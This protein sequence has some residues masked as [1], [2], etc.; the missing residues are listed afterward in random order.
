M[1]NFL[2]AK[3][4]FVLQELHRSTDDRRIADRIKAVL[5]LD[6]GWSS[7]D[8]CEAL[9]IDDSTIR[10]YRKLYENE[11][12]D[13]LIDFKYMGGQCH[14]TEK[15]LQKLE[16]HLQKEVYSSALEIVEHV[17]EEFDVEYTPEGMVKLL[18]RRGFVYKKTKQLPGKADAQ[19]QKE[20]IAKYRKVKKNKGKHDKIYFVDGTHPLHNSQPGYGWIKKGEIKEV[21]SNAGR[22]RVN[23]NGALDI[24]DLDFRFT[25]DKSINAQSTIKLFRKLE[26]A[27]PLAKSIYVITDN[28]KYYRAKLVKDYVEN[29]RIK[30]MFLPAYSPNL[31]IIERLWKFFHKKITINKYYEKYSDFRDNCLLFFRKLKKYKIELKTLLTDNFQILNAGKS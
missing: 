9:L 15:Q 20:F 31:N 5:L 8:I 7:T 21:K 17:K 29:S 24:E 11:G 2:D 6:K 30:L 28:A 4:R 13:G 25:S 23:I 16:E 27:N 18:K 26:R 12:V 10:K 3:D 22:D 19:K 1:S 14:L